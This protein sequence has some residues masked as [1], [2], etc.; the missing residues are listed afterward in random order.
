[1]ATSLAVRLACQ[2]TAPGGPRRQRRHVGRFQC[3]AQQQDDTGP[4]SRRATLAMLG[5]A[6]CP[7]AQL[8]AAN[9]ARAAAATDVGGDEGLPPLSAA[10]SAAV[11]TTVT[12]RLYIDLGLC[13]EAVRANRTLGDK[14][15]FCKEPQPLGRIV[16]DLY[17][18]AAPG[19]VATIVAAARA[20]AY[21]NTALS[22]VL[23][24]QYIV[25]GAQGPKRSGL[26]QAPEGLPAN[27]DILSSS[28][29]RLTHRRPGTVS[30]NLSESEDGDYMRFDKSY[31]NLSLLITTGPGPV[32]SLDG[33][34]I[35]VGQVTEGL[36]V[37][38]AVT[39][40]PTFTP[41]SNSRA[42]NDFANFIGDD[43]AAKTKSKWGRPL[44]AILIT[45]AGVLDGA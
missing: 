3:R 36:E 1:M 41:N 18:K 24:G 6:A 45:S 19:S 7:A 21:D 9:G 37:I 32:P 2:P 28:A 29:F 40:V 30:L 33:E 11:D 35:V 25:A 23:P 26:V 13:P 31:R 44:Q 34:N 22:K 12:H 43:R 4:A 8:L 38:R 39:Q 10:A 16:V 27:P 14:T 17:G 20:G 42:F 5:L 15:P